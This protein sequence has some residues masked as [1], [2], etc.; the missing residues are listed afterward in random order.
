MMMYHP[1]KL[2]CRKISSS[3]DMV[4]TVISDYMSPPC[5]LELEDRKQILDGTLAHD[6]ASPYPVWFQKVQW[7]GRYHLDDHSLEYRTFPVTLTL[8]TIEQSN[9]FTRQSS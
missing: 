8:T 6:D 5:D 9:L 3:A 2:G 7:L 4:E 1:I